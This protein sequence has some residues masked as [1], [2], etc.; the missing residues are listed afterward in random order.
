VISI[1]SAA[2]QC[3]GGDQCIFAVLSN[4]EFLAEGTAIFDLESPDR[5]LIGSE[6][7]EAIEAFAS[8]YGHWVPQERILRTNLWS[9]GHLILP[10]TPSC[11]AD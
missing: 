5:V 1:L 7:P 9:S 2:E 3:S 6:H 10:P 8:V 4:P 11:S